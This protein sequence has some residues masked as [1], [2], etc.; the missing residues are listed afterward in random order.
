[1][2]RLLSGNINMILKQA[3]YKPTDKGTVNKLDFRRYLKLISLVFIIY[4]WYFVT[5]T[6]LLMKYC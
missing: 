2:Q 6:Q 4:I 1:M 5:R 3:V